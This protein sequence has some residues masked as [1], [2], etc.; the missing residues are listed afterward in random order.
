[1]NINNLE[2]NSK[3]KNKYSNR[4]CIITKIEKVMVGKNDGKCKYTMVFT[5]SGPEPMASARYN[6]YF[7]TKDW[8]MVI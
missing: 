2:I 1:M 8:E 7:I 5:L 3:V 6:E 4:E